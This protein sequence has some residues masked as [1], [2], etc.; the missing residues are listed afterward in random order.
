MPVIRAAIAAL[1]AALF[2]VAI[3]AGIAHF[4]N[5][6]I[7]LAAWGLGA[8]IG[9]A[10]VASVNFR[11]S[12]IIAVIA[13]VASVA[14][15]AGGKYAGAYLDVQ[16]YI[17]E[18]GLNEATQEFILSYVADDVAAE[19]EAKRIKLD[20]PKAPSED[21]DPYREVDYPPMLWAEAERRWDTM[22]PEQQAVHTANANAGQM[23]FA[24][25]VQ[26]EATMTNFK[27]SFSGF[28]MLWFGFAV[29]TAFKLGIADRGSPQPGGD[30][31]PMPEGPQLS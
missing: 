19:L 10:T 4:F 30:E 14:S 11:G 13:V 21:F 25:V 8:M 7:G 12:L 15:I 29:F 17:E 20:W 6:E 2:G 1:G 31:G 23:A 24:R 9:Y 22:T 5:M 3:W 28:D 27:A 26:T 16:A 18:A